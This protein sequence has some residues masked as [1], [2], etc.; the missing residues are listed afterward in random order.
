MQRYVDRGVCAVGGK[1]ERLA[2]GAGGEHFSFYLTGDTERPS[3]LVFGDAD[4]AR[5]SKET[6]FKYGDASEPT[7]R[8]TTC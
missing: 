8:T 3:Q 1:R 5:Y 7:S 6:E 2:M 4:P